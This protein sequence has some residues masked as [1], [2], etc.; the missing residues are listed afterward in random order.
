MQRT[1]IGFVTLLLVVAGPGRALE[2][3]A[4]DRIAIVG[5]GF[6]EGMYRHGWLEAALQAA[7]PEKSLRVRNMG[8]SGDTPAM[9]PRALNFGSMT[10]HLAQQQIDVVIASWGMNESFAGAA[11]LA[12][13][14]Q[15]LLAWIDEMQ[16]SRFNGRTAPRL[17]L[18][19]PIAHEDLGPPLPD[20]RAHNA[21]IAR[22]T[23]AM[24]AIA[25]G[26]AV[27]FVDLYAPSLAYYRRGGRPLTRNGIHPTEYGYWYLAREIARQ[28]GVAPAAEGAADRD[29]VQALR[30]AIWDR[31]WHFFLYWRPVNME[32]I[33]GRRREP[34]GVENFPREFK[35]LNDMVEARDE[36]IW[37]RA[38]DV[39]GA[40]WD[41]QP[42]AR[43]LWER[44]PV[45]ES[46]APGQVP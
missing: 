35:Q 19:S 34:F 26:Q 16:Q 33:R 20:G 2:L 39:Q 14:E 31:N 15:D 29:A 7:H 11:G 37:Q 46:Q 44:L 17:V 43:E 41:W 24:R 9:Q 40:V 10:E 4:G 5:N 18:L 12:R 22:Y 32:Y 21:D 23:E 45:Y 27:D 36:I 13:F 3:E 1:I 38:A 8:W 25:A 30:A 6:A 28:L 42:A